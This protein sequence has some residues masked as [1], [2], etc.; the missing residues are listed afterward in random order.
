M[1][2]ILL[3]LLTRVSAALLPP[4]PPMGKNGAMRLLLR[5]AHEDEGNN[6]PIGWGNLTTD[7]KALHSSFYGELR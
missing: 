4:A 3:S 7:E 5:K 2:Q 6:P 1:K